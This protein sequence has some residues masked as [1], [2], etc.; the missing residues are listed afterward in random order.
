VNILA[1]STQCRRVTD[2]QTDGQTSCHS[3]VHAHA[4]HRVEKNCGSVCK[5]ARDSGHVTVI[6]GRQGLAQHR[7]VAARLS[8]DINLFISAK[9]LNYDYDADKFQRMEWTRKL[10]RYQDVLDG[11]LDAWIRKIC[12]AI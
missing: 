11:S 7:L 1:A 9:R 4:E 2:G 5:L 12:Q 3:I 6:D 10:A 8:L